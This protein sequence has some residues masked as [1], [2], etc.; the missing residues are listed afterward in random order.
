[1]AVTAC[2]QPNTSSIS[3]AFDLAGGN[4]LPATVPQYTSSGSVHNIPPT[5][6]KAVG[7]V[8]SGWR[9]FDAS[10]KPLVAPDFGYGIMQITSG[11]PGAFGNVRGNIAPASQSS[12][13]SDYFYNIAYGAKMLVD[14]WNSTPRIGN[15]DPS[16]IEN[17]YFALWAYN[18]WGWVNNPNN[19]RF[20][21]LGTPAQNS[22]A[23]PYQE[24]VLYLAQ[25]PPRDRAGNPLWKPVDVTLPSASVVG[26]SPHSFMPKTS[27]SQ[28]VQALSAVYKGSASFS[29]LPSST[30]SIPVKVENTGT[31]PWP[32]TGTLAVSLTYHLMTS[33]GNPWS[34]L[35]PFSK[36]VISFAQGQTVLPHDLLPG[37]S[38]SVHMPV[39]VPAAPGTYRVVW[40]LQQGTDIWFSQQGV[41]PL[42]AL[43]H[44]SASL[45]ATSTPGPTSL[46][47]STK[48]EDAQYVRDT[49]VPDGTVL[50]PGQAFE[51]GWLLFNNGKTAWGL[52]WSVRH[53]SGSTFG[54]KTGPLPTT[55][56]CRSLNF[57]STLHAPRHA[58]SYSGVWRVYD[59]NETAVG[60]RFTV[61]IT[62]RGTSGG[63]TPTPTPVPSP[64]AAGRAIPTP[65]PTPVG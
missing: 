25:H 27:H 23:F 32:S 30:V 44:V 10:G 24:R 3:A 14:K 16:V 6:L 51:K 36:G 29:A 5:L 41:L 35:S 60:D 22:G 39:R 2:S 65:T 54:F 42:A 1:M 62:V 18:G 53:L 21:R 49:S 48:T 12:V 58:G 17:W 57:V 26:N 15:G 34:P 52:G 20:G 13:A 56:V 31:L 28:P 37:K 55:P 59:S 38:V 40:D 47:K 8:E 9:Q 7:W 61:V 50:T 64:T 63:V 11:M 45:A 19:P 46:P 4:L 43:M 33:D